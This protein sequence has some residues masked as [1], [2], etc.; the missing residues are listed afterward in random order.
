MK[1][2]KRHFPGLYCLKNRS[3]E[4]WRFLD[5]NDTLTPL[6]KRQCFDFLNFLFFSL[7]RLFFVLEYRERH[8]P[9]LY[10]LRKQVGIMVIFGQKPLV[11]PL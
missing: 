3:L 2:R 7:D 4:K 5:Q 8:S 1:Y 10:C 9:C 11:N 6:E